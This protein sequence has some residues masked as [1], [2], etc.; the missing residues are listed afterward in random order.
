MVSFQSHFNNSAPT[1]AT[2]EPACL[3]GLFPISSHNTPRRANPENILLLADRGETMAASQLHVN[4]PNPQI[5]V[6]PGGGRLFRRGHFHFQD[7][8][9]L[10]GASL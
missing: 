10:T 5:R 2:H 7:Q 9:V 3:S 6:R 4:S 1:S 8:E